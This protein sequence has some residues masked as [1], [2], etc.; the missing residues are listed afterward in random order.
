[1][2][3]P[4][5]ARLSLPRAGMLDVSAARLGSFLSCRNYSRARLRLRRCCFWP[6]GLFAEPSTGSQPVQRC[7][8][9][10][11]WTMQS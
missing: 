9:E 8:V 1:M 3:K 5:R 11:C 10:L 2:G 7:A 4:C 6:D